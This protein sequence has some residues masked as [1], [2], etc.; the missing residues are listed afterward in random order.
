MNDRLTLG[1]HVALTQL[2]LRWIRPRELAEHLDPQATLAVGLDPSR[3]VIAQLAVTDAGTLGLLEE[4]GDPL[5]PP[6]NP[7]LIQPADVAFPQRV[8]DG[9]TMQAPCADGGAVFLLANA[10]VLVGLGGEG[11][12]DHVTFTD[13]VSGAVHS[14]SL[15]GPR[16]GRVLA[17]AMHITRMEALVLDE[18][19]E[20]PRGRHARGRGAR[21]V[22]FL[23]I[24]LESGASREVA[25]LPRL[26]AFDRHQLVGLADGRY[27]L[28]SV[29]ERA[30]RTW[31]FALSATGE[32]L[33]PTG[34][35]RMRGHPVGAAVSSQRGLSLPFRRPRD[36]TWAPRAVPPSDLRACHLRD[37]RAAL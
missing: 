23:L 18:H 34:L 7:A 12:V 32:S 20:P 33:V 30:D 15:S 4:K 5:P 29:N 9:C 35:R 3:Q 36:A 1:A 25:R 26:S 13:L 2:G 24:D 19:V 11:G 14:I 17:A 22:R 27:G 10:H 37:L 28:V 6:Q 8:S 31:V 16:P 21:F